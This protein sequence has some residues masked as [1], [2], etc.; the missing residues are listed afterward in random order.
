MSD[1]ASLG[2]VVEQLITFDAL[3]FVLMA[4]HCR[5]SHVE[6]AICVLLASV[7]KLWKSLANDFFVGHH[8]VFVVSI[9]DAFSTVAD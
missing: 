4:H 8:E 6:I 2:I 5:L 7:A 3:A 9:A 1:N